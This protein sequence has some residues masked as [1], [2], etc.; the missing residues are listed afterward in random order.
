MAVLDA[1]D[2]RV[3][4]IWREL[5]AAARP[6]YFL[7]WGWMDRWIDALPPYALPRLVVISEAGAPVAAAFL[8]RRR[9]TRHGVTRCGRP[10][11]TPPA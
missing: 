3:E 4:G 9:T 7:T 6:S 2:R 5:E 11:S 1:D 10:R 8:C